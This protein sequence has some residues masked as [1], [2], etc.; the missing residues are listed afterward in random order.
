MKADKAVDYTAG[1]R[2]ACAGSVGASVA[3]A[4]LGFMSNNF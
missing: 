1:T 3:G 4:F 2:A